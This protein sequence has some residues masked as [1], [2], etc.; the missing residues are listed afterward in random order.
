MNWSDPRE[1]SFQNGSRKVFFGDNDVAIL[2]FNE[3]YK[4]VN[5][6]GA[7]HKV[8]LGGPSRELH[9]DERWYECFIGGPGIRIDLDGDF[10]LVKI[11]GPP[12]QV[13]IGQS[14]KTDLVA[15]KINLIVDAKTVVPVFLDGKLQKFD[16]QGQTHT[17]RF[18]NQLQMALIDD[19]PFEISFGSLPKPV[20]LHD[21]KCYIRFSVLP[22]GIKPGHVNIQ[23]M[24]NI[25]LPV[26]QTEPVLPVFNKRVVQRGGANSPD[27]N[28]N[29]PLSF[30]NLFQQQ[31]LS[32]KFTTRKANIPTDPLTFSLLCRQSRNLVESNGFVANAQS[33]R[34]QS[35]LEQL[36]NRERRFSGIVFAESAGNSHFYRSS[37]YRRQCLTSLR[38]HQR[39]LPEVGGDRNRHYRSG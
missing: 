20:L 39:T 4:D 12:P 19:T 16:L 31:N 34:I 6:N 3:P 13:K 29:S 23:G 1:I 17:L 28:S 7:V 21:K 26:D 27:R 15:G 35:R 5:I 24:E 9:I 36:S 14:K 38:Q 10:V 37:G 18:I 32:S 30:Q 2:A 25:M 11:E 33:I 22:R 8:K